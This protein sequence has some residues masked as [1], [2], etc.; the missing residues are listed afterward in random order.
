MKL[1]WGHKIIIT[2]FFFFLI[3]GTLIYKSVN[4]DFQLVAE[5]YYA[6]E[7]AYQDKIEAVNNGKKLDA[8]IQ[9][10]GASLVVQV[11]EVEFSN[12]VV[13]FY[14][15]SDKALDFKI[16]LKLNEQ[17]QQIINTSA[18]KKGK[19]E[20]RVSFLHNEELHLIEEI[21]VL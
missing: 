17:S 14:R 7:I 2:F 19:W 8:F 6:D 3:M 15:S 9:Q 1:N 13:Y 20:V 11:K 21:I 4:T 16:D 5:D 10:Q 18:M 12:G